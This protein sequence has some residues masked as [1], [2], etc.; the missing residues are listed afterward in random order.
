MVSIVTKNKR[1]GVDQVLTS[2]SS[3]S[4]LLKILHFSK[5]TLPKRA[6]IVWRHL[7]ELTY[8]SHFPLPAPL[9]PSPIKLHR[10]FYSP[11]SAM[12]SKTSHDTQ[13]HTPRGDSSKKKPS[14][15]LNLQEEVERL[16]ASMT[17][18]M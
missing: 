10:L 11:P 5:L 7:W 6:S 12:P 1:Y 16:H 15:E 4:S 17:K 18:M 14:V 2:L 13:R 9:A 8:E 3:P